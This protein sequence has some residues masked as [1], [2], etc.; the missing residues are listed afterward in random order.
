MANKMAFALWHETVS[1]Q[2]FRALVSSLVTCIISHTKKLQMIVLHI[3]VLLFS[4]KKLIIQA[5]NF[6]L[7]FELAT[8]SPP[9]SLE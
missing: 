8:L 1:I 3:L 9:T 4:L 5:V 7:F 6:C 2:D